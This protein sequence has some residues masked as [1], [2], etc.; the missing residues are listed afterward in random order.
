MRLWIA[1]LIVLPAGLLFAYDYL[2]GC[3]GV[4][5]SG[6]GRCDGTITPFL[7][8]GSIVLA[9]VVTLVITIIRW[10]RR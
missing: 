3:I 6:T 2:F 5:R 8:L 1:V 10:A 4:A 7:L 9:L